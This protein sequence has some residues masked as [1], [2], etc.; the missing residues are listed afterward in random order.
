MLIHSGRNL[1]LTR[2]MPADLSLSDH[3]QQVRDRYSL[4]PTIL[5]AEAPA[6]YTVGVNNLLPWPFEL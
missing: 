6:A 5:A 2:S 4:T 1:S 3:Y